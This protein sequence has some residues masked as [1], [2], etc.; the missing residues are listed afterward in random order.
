MHNRSAQR[1]LARRWARD[2]GPRWEGHT[3]QT[4]VAEVRKG[5]SCR[6]ARARPTSSLASFCSQ[7]FNSRNETPS[8]R[9]FCSADCDARVLVAA[10][11]AP[12]SWPPHRCAA[13]I[14]ILPAIHVMLTIVCLSAA[15]S[16]PCAAQPKGAAEAAS[17]SDSIIACE[18]LAATQADRHALPIPCIPIDELTHSSPNVPQP[19]RWPRCWP[20]ITRS[21]TH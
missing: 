8:K 4:P 10:A 16:V 5:L 18:Q 11:A 13:G 12:H 6:D 17:A 20:C 2:R 1:G 21:T 9:G 7:C 19:T 14:P 15:P 3:V